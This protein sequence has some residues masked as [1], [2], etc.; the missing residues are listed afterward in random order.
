[1]SEKVV[2]S[3]KFNS[4]ADAFRLLQKYKAAFRRMDPAGA[5][6]KTPA[7]VVFRLSKAQGA[8]RVDTLAYCVC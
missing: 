6:Y 5:L 7:G 3:V 2:Q 8:V 4:E 1:M